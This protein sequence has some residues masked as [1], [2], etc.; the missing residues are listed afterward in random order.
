MQCIILQNRS[1]T[2]KLQ[3]YYQLKIEANS[4]QLQQPLN[5]SHQLHLA[6]LPHIKAS[7]SISSN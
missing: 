1:S 7:I 2:S 6:L 4:Q 5:Q 3:S